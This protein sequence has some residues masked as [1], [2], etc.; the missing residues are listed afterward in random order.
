VTN[1]AVSRWEANGGYPDMEIIPSIANY[2]HIAIDELFGYNNDR[3]ERVRKIIV[4]AGA[5]MEAREDMESYVAVL[6]NAVLEFPSEAGILLELGYALLMCGF[7]KHGLRRT[8][9]DEYDYAVNDIEYNIKN[10]YVT[11]ALEIFEK[12][13][14]MGINPDDRRVV[15]LYIVRIYAM[16]GA[17]D[18]A[19]EI[20][21]KQDS[22]VISRECLLPNAA[23]G[24]KRYIY[25]GEALLALTRQLQRSISGA[26]DIKS[27]LR[28]SESGV[29]KLL[30][31]AHLYEL[32]LDDG[33]Y[34]EFHFDL[35]NIYRLCSIYTARQGDI[36]K[37]IEYFDVCFHHGKRF[38][39][40]RNN[41]ISRYTAS[42]V[43]G[44]TTSGNE[45]PKVPTDLWKN[46]L[47]SAPASL[48]EA[49]KSNKKYAKLFANN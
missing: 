30:G 10:A 24:E 21:N 31:V 5:M 36:P 38:M 47:G 35:W 23:D 39:A 15:I 22:V 32:I 4:D 8:I 16:M 6:R 27:T 11:E 26:V 20:A 14:S 13:L 17:Y 48:I 28:N 40:I 18:K 33:N 45:W 12:V 29:Q 37:A 7:Q 2:F 1:Q 46:W 49:I 25:Q 19:E 9:K 34:E 41:G 3:D 43:S 44:V 42:L